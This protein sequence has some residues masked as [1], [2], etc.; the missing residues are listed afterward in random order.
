MRLRPFP[1]NTLWLNT[2]RPL[3]W[4][5]LK[6]HVVLIDFWTT[7]CINCVHVIPDLKWLEDK[8]KN[9]P[10]IVIGVHSAK[11]ENEKAVQNIESAIERF[12]INHPVIVDSQRSLWNTYGIS[13]WPSYLLAGADG[14]IIGKVAGEGVRSVLDKAIRKALE[15]GRNRG[16]LTGRRF[17]NVQRR[18]KETMLS[19]PSKIE[20]D[21]EKNHLFISD[22][23]HNRI[24]QIEISGTSKGKIIEVIGGKEK[25]MEDG[26]FESARFNYPQGIACYNDA[27]YICDTG[28]HTIRKADLKNKVVETVAGNGCQANWGEKGGK[29]IEAPLNSPWDLVQ[30][31]GSLY[32]T[33]AGAHQIWVLDLKEHTIKVFAG[34][35]SEN[36]EDGYPQFAQ[37]AQPCG[38]TTDGERIYFAD[39]GVS[40]LRSSRLSD[41]VVRTH[42]GD[43]LFTYGFKDE[44]FNKA[45]MQRPLGVHYHDQK[46]YIADTYNHAVRVADFRESA[47]RT[48]IYPNQSSTYFGECVQSDLLPLNEP[49]DVAF[50]NGL[51]YIADTNNHRIGVFDMEKGS[52]ET[53]R[54]IE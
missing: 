1:E 8:Y 50:H 7:S 4:E 26:G 15:D 16:L 19:Y 53:L 52:L 43:G 41:G 22:T 35:G 30:I 11:F 14:E 20:M 37:L 29:A 46:V 28:N 33:M 39:S 45:M 34:V 6:G 32:I 24:L 31:E 17:N 44:V 18:K 23:S 38:I 47:L 49:N 21:K 12:E 2:E 13:T 48:L 27:L 3:K 10:L 9:H 36:I 25:G 54:I 5:D 42:I 51:L 40:S